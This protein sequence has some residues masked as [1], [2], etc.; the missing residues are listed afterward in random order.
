MFVLRNAWTAMTRHKT[1][2]ILVLV[3]SLVMAAGSMFGLSARYS[4]ESAVGPI[5]QSLSPDAKIAVDRT[6][7]M[8]SKGVSDASKVNWNEYNISWATWVKYAEAVSNA[9]VQFTPQYDET[10]VVPAA[11]GKLQPVDGQTFTVTGFSDAGASQD[12]ALGGYRIVDGQ[13]LGFDQD[14]ITN[15]IIPKALADRNGTKVGDQIELA[16]PSDTSKTFSL[17]VVGIYENTSDTSAR[18]PTTGGAIDPNNAIYV[19]FSSFGTAQL[20]PEDENK[21]DNVLNVTFKFDSLGDYETYR[22]LVKQNGLSDDYVV[23]SPKIAAF[24]TD[25]QPLK[26]LGSKLTPALIALWSVGG[27]MLALLLAWTMASR[28]EEIGYDVTMGV[29]RARIGWQFALEMILPALAGVIAGYLG[30]GFGTAPIIAKLTTAVHGTPLGN[31]I[32]PCIW[33]ALGVLAAFAVIGWIRVGCYRNATLLAG[34]DAVDASDASKSD[35]SDTSD[36]KSDT[37]EA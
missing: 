9:G 3:V 28:G 20:T 4:Y 19:S 17:K 5:Y 6:H 33:A 14:T 37:K 2:T 1:R 32:W 27:V 7:V 25:I 11:S 24:E 16:I 23:T 35:T 12:G 31:T 21:N 29:S 22:T 18:T 15:A 8:A 13:D 36:T 34:R 26:D 10:A 30:A